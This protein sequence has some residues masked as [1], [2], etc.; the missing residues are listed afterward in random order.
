M[1]VIRTLL[2]D[3]GWDVDCTLV[4]VDVDVVEMFVFFQRE[5]ARVQSLRHRI[6]DLSRTAA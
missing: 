5:F 6:A 1:Y 2:V 3:V 4:D